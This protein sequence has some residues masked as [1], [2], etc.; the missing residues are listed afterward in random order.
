MRFVTGVL[1][2]IPNE[3]VGSDLW[4]VAAEIALRW[5][6]GDDERVFTSRFDVFVHSTGMGQLMDTLSHNEVGASTGVGRRCRQGKC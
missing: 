4:S 1:K 2:S 5:V 3:A 6:A